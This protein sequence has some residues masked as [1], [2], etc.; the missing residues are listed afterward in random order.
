M[1]ATEVWRH[2]TEDEQCMIRAA[3]RKPPAERGQDEQALLRTFWRL[4]KRRT[5]DRL[6]TVDNHRVNAGYHEWLRKSGLPEKFD[7]KTYDIY[8]RIHG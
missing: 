5:R 4:H 1:R 7:R 8:R 6:P 3:L 2:F